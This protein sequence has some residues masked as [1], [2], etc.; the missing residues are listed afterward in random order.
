MAKVKRI[1]SDEQKQAAADRMREFQ[2]ARWAKIHALQ[3]ETLAKEA[4]LNNA[5]IASALEVHQQMERGVTTTV[6]MDPPAEVH[7]E[8]NNDPINVPV[9]HPVRMGSRQVSLVV[10]NDGQMVSQFGPCVCGAVK[11]QWH[12]ICLKE[13]GDH[14]RK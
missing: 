14:G 2:K 3:A 4:A 8:M 9:V 11:R 10:R 6:T 1:W 5:G 12:A 7:F 13:K